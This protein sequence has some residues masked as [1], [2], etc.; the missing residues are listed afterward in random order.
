MV[1]LVNLSYY[2]VV[3]KVVHYCIKTLKYIKG[4]QSNLCMRTP[5][6]SGFKSTKASLNLSH[7]TL[8]GSFRRSEQRPPVNSEATFV[9]P[10]A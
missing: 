3:L 2:K 1:L 8:I 10:R 7:D 6:S 5:A 9:I 4:I